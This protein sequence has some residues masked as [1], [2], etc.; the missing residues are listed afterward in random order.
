MWRRYSPLSPD[1][2]LR[3]FAATLARN[4]NRL[5]GR[6]Q[7]VRPT[8]R[9]TVGKSASRRLRKKPLLVH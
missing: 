5:E 3:S 8:R 7:F 6:L 4:L 1:K 2:L 9:G